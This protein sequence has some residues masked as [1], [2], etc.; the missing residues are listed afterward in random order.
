MTTSVLVFVA[1]VALYQFG[2][3]T[4]VTLA[5]IA[6]VVIATLTDKRNRPRRVAR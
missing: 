4:Y 1:Y 3:V 5:G 2:G 6:W